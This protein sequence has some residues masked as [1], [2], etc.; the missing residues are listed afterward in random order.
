MRKPT[1]LGA[2]A[3]LVTA[4]GGYLGLINPQTTT[5]TDLRV[6]L[7]GVRSANEATAAQI[8]QLK[9]QLEDIS[10][11]VDALRALSQQVPPSIDLPTLYA[12]LDTV[13]AQVG[14]GV[15]VTNV[16]V[17]IP[18]LLATTE[19]AA[20]PTDPTTGD[21]AA[22][23][24]GTTEPADPNLTDPAATPVA[25][26]AAAVLASYEVTIT[27]KATPEQAAAFI[28][29]L[30]QTKRLNVVST[31]GVGGGAEADG[32]TLNVTATFYLQQ[33][34]VDGLAAQIEALA[35]GQ[36][37]I[38]PGADIVPNDQAAAP[39]EEASSDN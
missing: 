3:C 23:T 25:P 10:G 28:R 4:A 18:T 21:P 19:P 13:A 2:V 26:A 7:D 17:T 22:P 30:G 27:L 11:D 33:V 9:A 32:G 16:T 37:V 15:A 14:G 24:D 1:L 39:D 6:E 8:P 20:A 12:E 5:N 29:A 36:G 35:N 38:A 31:S 34:D